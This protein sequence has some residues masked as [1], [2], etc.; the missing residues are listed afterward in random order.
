MWLQQAS[1][2]AGIHRVVTLAETYLELSKTK[3]P[4]IAELP[5]F[6]Q[7]SHY[8]HQRYSAWPREHHGWFTLVEQ[9]G[10][11]GIIQRL[12][13]YWQNPAFKKRDDLVSSAQN[14]AFYVA[15]YLHQHYLPA[16]A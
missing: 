8:L 1:P 7:Y 13:E 9:E 3:E 5:Y 2:Q 15:R 6:F 14:Q 11:H 16:P 10:T 4:D 12:Q